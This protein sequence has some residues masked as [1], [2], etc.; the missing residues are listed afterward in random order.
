MKSNQGKK[1][2]DNWAIKFCMVVIMVNTTYLS[3]S[4]KWWLWCFLWGTGSKRS[5]CQ[6]KVPR[7]LLFQS[8]Q[9][10]TQQFG[11]FWGW[12][13]DTHHALHHVSQIV[14]V[15]HKHWILI[16]T[17]TPWELFQHQKVIRWRVKH[18]DHDSQGSGIEPWICISIRVTSGSDLNSLCHHFLICVMKSQCPV[19][20]LPVTWDW[21]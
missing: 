15:S 8:H 2:H 5:H 14:P 12:Q 20:S 13:C 1:H 18:T 17:L 21:N 6:M 11:T 10:Q 16:L 4:L 3:L 7:V 19:L 9:I